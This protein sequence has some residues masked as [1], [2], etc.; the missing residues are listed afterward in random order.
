MASKSYNTKKT[1][2][3]INKKNTSSQGGMSGVSTGKGTTPGGHASG[4]GGGKGSSNGQGGMAGTWWGGLWNSNSSSSHSSGGSSSSSHSSGGGSS[5]GG[6]GGGGGGG[7]GGGSGWRAPTPSTKKYALATET[8]KPSLGAGA[9]IK[10]AA[11]KAPAYK[12]LAQKTIHDTAENAHVGAASGKT[13]YDTSDMTIYRPTPRPVVAP[14]AA[15]PV[16]G[17][18]MSGAGRPAL[19]MA[20]LPAAH[21]TPSAPDTSIKPL[22]TAPGSSVGGFATLSPLT[23]PRRTFALNQGVGSTG[24]MLQ[25]IGGQRQGP[26]SSS[27]LGTPPP[28]GANAARLGPVRSYKAGRG[29]GGF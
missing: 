11:Y 14:A 20:A 8:L 9:T 25:P 4:S 7:S 6:G 17:F 22:G 18:G 1:A 16:G 28:I 19:Q 29:F 26:M 10:N 27:G 15:A 5:G 21:G 13:L 24:P 23:Q 12:P 3:S 2:S